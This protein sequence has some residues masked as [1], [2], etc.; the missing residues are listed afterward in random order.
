M[1][2][3]LRLSLVLFLTVVVA[4]RAPRSFAQE[5][6][7]P[8][9]RVLI[10]F[11]PAAELRMAQDCASIVEEAGGIV[12]Y[13]FD[14]IPVVSAW[15]SEQALATLA[16]RP[17]IAYVEEDPVMY[18]F[19]QTTPWGVDRID[20]D[21]VWPGGN[22]GA[23]VDVAII[24]TGIDGRHP[25]LA[26]VD[27]INYAGPPA[28]EGSTDPADW[29]DGYG[30]GTHC[31]GIVA[32]LNNG[33]GVVGV[34]PGARLHAV[35]V[36]DDFGLGYTSDV[37]QGLEWCA[38]NHVHVASLSL[39]GG[40]STSLQAACDAAFAAG[41]LLVAAAG[42]SSGP[43]SFPA[44]YPSV[45]AVSAT[46]SKDQLAYFSN[47]GP[48]IALGAP[49]VSIY[50]TFKGGAYA[51]MSG[52]S[53]ACPH[54]TGAAAL[55]WAAGA[56][57]NAAVRDTL[58]GAAED[59]GTVGRD[60]SFGYGLVDAQKAAGIGTTT[61]RITNPADGATVSGTVTIE[62]TARSDSGIVGVE[63]F[64]DTTSIGSGIKGTDGWSIAWDT[65]L[66]HDSAYQ[67]VAVAT[68]TLGQTARHSINVVVDNAAQ[69]PP[70][71]HDDARLGHRHVGDEDQPGLPDPDQGCGRRRL[72]ALAAA[73]VRG[74]GLCDHHAAER[75]IDPE[76]GRHRLRWRGGPV[77]LVE[78]RGNLHL[79]R[80]GGE[81][82]ARLRSFGQSGDHRIMLC[83]LTTP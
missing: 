76:M 6:Q 23:G 69:K 35:K 26:V 28:Q 11:T 48:E 59:L 56:V 32:A 3:P 19:G 47:F 44:A 71:T 70:A 58:T 51:E 27:G 9:Y 40:G 45:V 67:V 24:D 74:D 30:H 73:G 49:G 20:A 55:V 22:T 18:A 41:V 83:T 5:A 31:A 79:D 17:D 39:G 25:D 10:G 1:R 21:L 7:P 52:T 4:G 61:V 68:D 14:L 12:H 65:T 78:H 75:K 36:L 81:R 8:G 42:N 37:I 34:A 82:L 72:L 63:F 57:S 2:T 77:D 38:K 15:V 60:P 13:A 33:I 29:N 62:A 50:S 43:V 64:V 16:N 53:M 80:D 46:D 54:V 66:F